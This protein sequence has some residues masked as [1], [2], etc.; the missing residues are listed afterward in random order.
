[1][2]STALCSF[3]GC[4]RA[5]IV[6][7]R[8]LCQTHHK[9]AMAGEELRPIRAT[10][11]ARYGKCSFDGCNYIA[12]DAKTRLCSAHIT[13]RM[14]GVPLRPAR[15]RVSS[16]ARD[17]DGNKWCF[18]CQEW[19]P[20]DLFS[21]SSGKLDGLQSRCKACAKSLYEATRS[22]VRAA[23]RKGKYG[24]S[25]DAFNGLL[26][27]QGGVCAVCGTDEPGSKFWAVDH[28]HSCCP[29]PGSCGKCVRG[30]LCGACNLG[31]GAFRDNPDSLRS[32]VEYLARF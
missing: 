23:N 20:E 19:K 10:N 26:R 14:S 17:D 9:Q 3:P 29:G 24:L 30:I 7:K 4:G 32:A 18:G 27:S 25:S 8:R 21:K 5:S 13:Q 28:D 22:D 31:L 2:Q 15:R 6:K 11:R 1:M 16:L 12:R